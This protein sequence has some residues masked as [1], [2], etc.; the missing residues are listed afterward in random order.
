MT[1]THLPALNFTATHFQ[2]T[3]GKLSLGISYFPVGKHITVSFMSV[4]SLSTSSTVIFWKVEAQMMST[5]PPMGV[6]YSSV[7][8][9]V[10]SMIT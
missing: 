3:F 5:E 6:L 7:A 9:V 1:K 10:R 8:K 4:E 2:P